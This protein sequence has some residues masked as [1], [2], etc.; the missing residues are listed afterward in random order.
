MKVE[1]DVFEKMPLENQ[2]L[3]IFDSIEDLK[4]GINIKIAFYA[5]IGGILGGAGV[6]ISPL[7]F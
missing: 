7:I 1:R 6:K 3:V 5:V 4:K 2:M